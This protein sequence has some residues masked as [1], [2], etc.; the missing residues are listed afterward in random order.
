[1]TTLNQ[2]REAV[3]QRFV[4][5]WANRTLFAFE[6]EDFKTPEDPQKDWVR[7]VVRNIGGG[8]ETIGP[9]GGRK[10]R[11]KALTFVQIFTPVNRGLKIPDGHAQAARAIFEGV[12]FNGLDFDDSFATEL[13]SR[14]GKWNQMNFEAR[15]AYEEVR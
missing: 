2:A 14:D 12:S 13:G 8:A 4:T 9:I 6:N 3:E 11:R 5:Q 7:V 10:Y 1:M 15:F